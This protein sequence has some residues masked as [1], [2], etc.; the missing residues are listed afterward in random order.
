MGL[1]GGVSKETGGCSFS[2]PLS[3]APAPTTGSYSGDGE[4]SGA[5]QDQFQL[6]RPGI[7]DRQCHISHN[8]Q[9]KPTKRET[10]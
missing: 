6:V 2:S 5:H 9:E 3:T 8:V 7:Q 1:L 4:E 10:I